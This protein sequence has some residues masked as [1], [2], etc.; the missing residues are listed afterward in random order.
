V[1]NGFL[2][3][4]RDYKEALV[5]EVKKRAK[6]PVKTSVILSIIGGFVYTS[7]TR[8]ERADFEATLISNS[9]KLSLVGEPI[10]NKRSERVNN[11][12]TMLDSMGRLR[13]RNLGVCT[14]VYDGL[15]D[16]QVK[17]FSVSSKYLKPRWTDSLYNIV[18]IGFV[19]RWW[20]MS[21]AMVDYD[22]S[23]EEWPGGEEYSTV[24]VE[25][26]RPLLS[27]VEQEEEVS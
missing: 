14:V 19:G 8:P 21:R 9:L 5:D 20:S 23:E 4:G 22:V 6:G 1:G 25:D 27:K 26:E 3:A 24:L 17:E 11:N 16:P 10:R 12:L 13:F 18:E 7:Y 15:H 2:Q